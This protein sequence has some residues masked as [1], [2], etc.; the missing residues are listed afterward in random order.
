VGSVEEVVERG[1][2]VVGRWEEEVEDGTQVTRRRPRGVLAC[3]FGPWTCFRSSQFVVEGPR[4]GGER[5]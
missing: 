4:D 5:E 2:E 1:A 3:T